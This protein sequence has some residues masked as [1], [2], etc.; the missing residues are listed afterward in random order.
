MTWLLPKR[1]HAGTRLKFLNT[2]HFAW[3]LFRRRIKLFIFFKSAH[4]SYTHFLLSMKQWTNRRTSQ[5]TNTSWCRNIRLCNLILQIL[6]ASFMLTERF[7]GGKMQFLQTILRAGFG[8]PKWS[9]NYV[10]ELLQNILMCP[11]PVSSL[12]RFRMVSTFL[13]VV[14]LLTQKR[15]YL[16]R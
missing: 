8:V 12:L 3:P 13:F 16:K 11:I 14:N 7:F 10:F 15:L 1:N 4:P 6:F 2:P 9:G 5:Y